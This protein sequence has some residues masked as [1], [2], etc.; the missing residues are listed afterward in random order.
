MNILSRQMMRLIL[1]SLQ[2][3]DD[4]PT[5]IIKLRRPDEF[6]LPPKEL[7]VP[8]GGVVSI[9]VTGSSDFGCSSANITIE[10][11]YGLKSPEFLVSKH[12]ED[13]DI[14]AHT[15]ANNVQN[16]YYHYLVPETWIQICLGYGW[17]V[18]PVLT[19]AIDKAVVD[20]EKATVQISVRDN[21]R[22][23]ID[24]H[25]DIMVH[26]S[27]LTYPRTDNLVVISDKDPYTSNN[28]RMVKIV[29]AD[30]YISVRTG[31]GTEYDAVGKAYNGQ[32]FQYMDETVNKYSKKWYKIL[33]DGQERWVYHEYAEL[34]NTSA[35][36]KS[37][38]V[39]RVDKL[40]NTDGNHLHV[41]NGP[42]V[43]Y[44]EIGLVFYGEVL[45][46]LETETVNGVPWFHITYINAGGQQ[47]DG[48]IC[49]L[50]ASVDED[51][52]AAHTV[53]D[54]HNHLHVKADHDSNS[55]DI[56]VVYDGNTYTYL[57]TYKDESGNYWHKIRFTGEDG[58]EYE[59]WLDDES[60]SYEQTASVISYHTVVQVHGVKSHLHIRS[61]PSTSFSV[62]TQ[63]SNNTVLPYLGSVQ[64]SDG[65]SIWHHVLYLGNDGKYHEGFAN[66]AY[67]RV[68]PG[69]RPNYTDNTDKPEPDPEIM[70]DMTVTTNPIN[71]K[72]TASAIVHDLAVQ[73][74]Y[75]GAR[76]G[77]SRLDRKI[78]D[79]WTSEY[80][81]E[82]S[83]TKQPSRYVINEIS[84]PYTLN[85]FDAALQVVNQMG[86]VTFRCNRYGDIML[87][88]NRKPTQHD[89]PDWEVKDYVDLTK[90]SLSYDVQDMRSRVLI[91]SDSGSSLFV[92][93]R[94]EFGP[95]KGVCRQFGIKVPFADTLEKRKEAA[96]SAFEQIMSNWR[97]MSIA[98]VG[99]PLIEIGHT[100]RIYDMVTTATS[101]FKV[102]EYRHQF[103]EEGFI[104]QIELSWVAEV[105]DSDVSLLSNRIPSYAK[106]FRYNLKFSAGNVKPMKLKLPSTVYEAM[107]RLKDP[108]TEEIF[109]TIDVKGQNDQMIVPTPTA[110][111]TYIKLLKDKVNIRTNPDL[112]K[113]Y[114]KKIRNAGFTMRFLAEVGNF[115][116]G[117]DP[118]DGKEAF[119]WKDYCTTYEQHGNSS[120][121]LLDMGAPEAFVS[122]V[123]SKV[124]C[125]YVWGGQGEILTKQRLNELINAYGRGHYI[126]AGEYDAST[127][128]GRQVFDC[129]GL[130][131]WALQ[132]MGLISRSSDYNAEGIFKDLCY[133][134]SRD[135]VQAG[136]LF[137]R[138]SKGGIYHVGVV[139]EGGQ[140]VEARGTSYGVIR[141]AL[142]KAEKFGRIKKLSNATSYQ[143]PDTGAPITIDINPIP[144]YYT[145]TTT[146]DVNSVS[147][148]VRDVVKQ[149][150]GNL[151]FYKDDCV[152]YYVGVESDGG[153]K[154]AIA[155]KWSPIN[156]TPKNLDLLYDILVF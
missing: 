133:E 44:N 40:K 119:I 29:N 8:E 95:C 98:I 20:S 125:G 88:R 100:V 65:N 9:E 112:D 92:N 19:G 111:V 131:V 27:A 1:S 70:V 155:L 7:T 99:N 71:N 96:K 150:N 6:H 147:Q 127:W 21:M 10:N 149:L 52:T 126:K 115:Y 104:T 64:G 94:I 91:I 5:Y 18:V 42:G 130:V 56:G 118:E 31:P 152:L 139:V 136:D 146:F 69:F 121:N 156:N 13:S 36:V 154:N 144:T 15:N 51:A 113:Q 25:I 151:L 33:F 76:G 23:L 54:F 85:Y 108:I 141:R 142:P 107:I 22:Y 90:A 55:A 16:E 138:Q 83:D 73:A 37:K 12:A 47:V 45:D 143:L 82:D 35:T 4:S 89:T 57:S 145:V 41:R 86:D 59:G 11:C 129:S 43:N 116:K 46:Y 120:L 14:I 117:I 106:R 135:N 134:I 81:I 61:G 140:V 74:L 68:Q 78:A 58:N 48:W 122:L 72:W 80:V 77:P 79:V 26:G 60:S 32:L 24:Q 63:V 53:K 109:A 93:K 103:T 102:E 97:R 105:L 87:F 28:T 62:L 148:E 114:I 101:I 17:M 49:G 84:F 137:F 153:D 34:L 123:E 66:S 110:P 30:S 67:L 75:V 3:G 2:V 128:I 50:Y 38:G 132:Q 124:G 39:V